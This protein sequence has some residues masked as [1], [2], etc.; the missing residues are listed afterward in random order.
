MNLQL[1][2]RPQ[3]LLNTCN[4]ENGIHREWEFKA[5]Y[6]R[7]NG[8]PSGSFNGKARIK[9]ASLSISGKFPKREKQI[10]LVDVGYVEHNNNVLDIR[11]CEFRLLLFGVKNITSIRDSLR[12]LIVRQRVPH[13]LLGK[14]FEWEVKPIKNHASL[15]NIE[16]TLFNCFCLR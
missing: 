14:P 4:E 10:A 8:L 6:Y 5:F 9:Y 13:S 1:L 12:F 11:G 15:T 16:I 2:K 3:P 7:K